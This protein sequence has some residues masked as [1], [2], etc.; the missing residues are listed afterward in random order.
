MLAEVFE[1][2]FRQRHASYMMV[3]VL[4]MLDYLSPGGSVEL[5]DVVQGF[6][7]YYATRINNG[8]V[9]E[10]E[11]KKMS[12]VQL[13]SDAEVKNLIITQPLAALS[14]LISYDENTGLV[15]INQ[16]LASELNNKKA[17]REL[18][19]T[20]FRH[21]YE[22]YKGL[23]TYQLT[24]KD[25]EALPLE[26]AASARDISLLSGQNQMKGI[27]PIERDEYRGVIILCTIAG[28]EYSNSWLDEEENLLKYYLE[29]RKV[30][31]RKMY[32]ENMK[33]NK[34]I[35]SSR[36]GGNPIHV[37][38][39]EQRGELF[40]YAGEFLYGRM[41]EDSDGN[42]FFVLHR[43]DLEGGESAPSPAPWTG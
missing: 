26:F 10:K 9:P 22:Y 28:N 23:Q 42:K 29:G 25:L 18:R 6:R 19:R 8:K 41:D 40:H 24:L 16:E 39:R 11:D 35:I 34:S 37:F 7:A 13:L 43:K 12:R 36:E 17:R 21:L 27:H 3:T 14:D 2:K 15:Q 5:S 38:V 32:N 20:A 1:R 30:D 31:D 33:S 4:A